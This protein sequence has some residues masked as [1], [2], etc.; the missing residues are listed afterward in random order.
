MQTLVAHVK[1]IAMHVLLV[2]SARRVQV[3]ITNIIKHVR[4]A[5]LRVRRAAL[6]AIIA[7]LAQMDIISM[8]RCVQHV[9]SVLKRALQTPL[10]L[11]ATRI[12]S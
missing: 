6:Q 7:R 5:A 9:E 8:G 2:I 12:I 1:L 4:L 11:H 3:T 10:T